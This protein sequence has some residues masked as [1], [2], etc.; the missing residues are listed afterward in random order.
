M[1]TPRPSA[2]N[3]LTAHL[4]PMTHDITKEKKKK[5]QAVKANNVSYRLH[6]APSLYCVTSFKPITTRLNHSIVGFVDPL[7][8]HFA[9]QCSQWYPIQGLIHKQFPHISRRLDVEWSGP[10]VRTSGWRTPHRIYGSHPLRE[11]SEGYGKMAAAH[12]S[13]HDF[14]Q[15]LMT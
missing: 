3:I 7:K 14:L 8:R 4:L 2:P 15:Q 9:N 6:P 13:P 12:V 1:N 5:K 10:C 11:D